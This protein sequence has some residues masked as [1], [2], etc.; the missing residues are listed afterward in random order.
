MIAT[1]LSNRS[2]HLPKSN[3]W[4]RN[5]LAGPARHFHTVNLN[6]PIYARNDMCSRDLGFSKN[7]F[8]PAQHPHSQ[9]RHDRNGDGDPLCA[10]FFF[11]C[12][13]CCCENAIPNIFCRCASGAIYICAETGVAHKIADVSIAVQYI[14]T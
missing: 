6:G 2:K 13:C 4:I 5:L 10:S 11:S 14:D 8:I 7:V 3:I 1:R 9:S 12:C